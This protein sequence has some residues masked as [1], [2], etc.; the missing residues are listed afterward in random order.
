MIEAD[1]VLSAAGVTANIEN[2]GLETLGIVVE[3]GS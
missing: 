1:L 3:K 2:I